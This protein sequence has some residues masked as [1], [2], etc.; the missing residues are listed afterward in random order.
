LRES[1]RFGCGSA[2]LGLC[3]KYSFTGNPEFGSLS[4]T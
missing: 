2:V 3:G 1:F 4:K